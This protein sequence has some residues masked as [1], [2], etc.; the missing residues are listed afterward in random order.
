MSFASTL[1]GMK[2]ELSSLKCFGT[3][4]EEALYEAFRHLFPRAIRLL[5]SLHMKAK[6]RELGVGD[7]VQ[8]VIIADIFGKQ[9]LSVQVEGVIVEMEFE[10]GITTLCSKWKRMDSHSH[11]PLHVFGTWFCQ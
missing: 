5:C 8:Q 4:G 2:P 10:K 3:D 6:L 7:N 11:G 1:L 9:V